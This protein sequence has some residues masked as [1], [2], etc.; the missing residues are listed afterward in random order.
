LLS[1]DF[2]ETCG[3]NGDIPAFAALLGS[4]PR[5]G[6]SV[7]LGLIAGFAGVLVFAAVLLFALRSGGGKE[8]RPS[9]DAA[10][11]RR[12][13]ARVPVDSDFDLF[14]Q[15]VDAAHKSVRAKGI[16]MSEGGISVRSPKP[17]AR[18]SRIR[19]T[20]RQIHYEGAAV[21]RRCDRKGLTYVIGLQLEGA[22]QKIRL[23][24]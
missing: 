22:L 2:S 16:E 12:K 9:G 17:I 8:M 13:A 4:R 23:D 5:K 21:V 1:L 3:N 7:P 20:A 14:Y 19:L 10:W 18:N 15:D 24:A 11:N 6:V